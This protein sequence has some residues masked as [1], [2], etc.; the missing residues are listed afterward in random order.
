[1]TNKIFSL[2]LLLV[3][4]LA[5]TGCSREEDDIFGKSAAERL[6]EIKAIYTDRLTA[7]TDGWA[8]QYYPQSDEEAYSVSQRGYLM[9]A[10]FKKDHTVDMA[11]NFWPR[12]YKSGNDDLVEYMH[13]YVSD[14]NS[15]WE[16]ITDN[17]PVLTFNSYNK[18]IHHF[19]D[20][21]NYSKPEGYK[22]DYE[23]VIIDAPED[24]SYIL[25]KGKKRG[26]YNLMTPLPAGTDFQTYLDDIENF[27]ETFFV[28][29]NPS[30][31]VILSGGK[32][33]QLKDMSSRYPRLYPEGTDPVIEGKNMPYLITKRG[34]D[35]YFRFKNTEKFGEQTIEQEY[36]YNANDD[37]FHGVKNNQN[38]IVSKYDKMSD[39]M[40]EQFDTEHHFKLFKDISKSAMSDKM[41]N[42][43]SDASNAMKKR[44]SSYHIDSL[45]ISKSADGEAQ[46]M[47]RYQSGKNAKNQ[48]YKYI[49]QQE[50]N[51]ITF[52][53]VEPA[54]SSAGNI[55]NAVP[56]IKTLIT[57]VLS[58][59]FIID[60]YTTIFDL[61]KIKLTSESDPEIW[62]VINF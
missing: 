54:E 31:P 47:F 16:I 46:W 5:F 34:N 19:S 41:K 51:T 24:G 12:W 1:M 35:Y 39:F 48:P 2:S 32:T 9:L 11:M 30:E 50:G 36:I 25:L 56:E 3:A 17:G 40:K 53:Y 57:E 20:P 43:I 27:Q 58:Q 22:G 37:K 4:T 33:F 45:S 42:Y 6:T 59:K 8:L 21:E 15:L 14:N 13:T 49:Y 29:K 55:L 62:F 38:V 61:T 44:N 23:F 18:V 28:D 52:T 10:K 26:T 60:K 7:N